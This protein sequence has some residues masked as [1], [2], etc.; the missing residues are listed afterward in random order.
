MRKHLGTIGL[1]VTTI[2][3]GAG[4]VANEIALRDLTPLQILSMRF[5]V[6]AIIMGVITLPALRKIRKEE[7][8]AGICLGTV[9]YISFA[10]QTF[11]LRYTTPSKNAFLTATNVVIVPFIEFI[12]YRKRVDQYGVMGAFLAIVGIA[13][14][15]LKGDLTLGIGDLLT[16]FCAFGFAFHIF[17]TGEYAKKY[18]VTILTTLQ[19]VVAAVLSLLCLGFEEGIPEA[20]S[21]DGW[22]SV[23]YLGVFSTTVAFFLQTASQKYMEQTK[24]AIILS[25]EAVFGTIGSVLIVHEKITIRMVIGCILILLAVII[26]ETK[27]SFFKRQIVVTETYTNN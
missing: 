26:A 22:I 27:L 4:F 6:A 24:A 15:S 3:W 8:L 25:M 17:L 18:S 13:V 20:V 14:L 5:L 21:L 10:A 16:I 1:F 19:M 11:G 9:L 2:I 12:L 23:L 7:L